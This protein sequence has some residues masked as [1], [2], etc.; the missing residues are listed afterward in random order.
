[1]VVALVFLGAFGVVGFFLAALG[2]GVDGDSDEPSNESSALS[3]ET[4]VFLGLVAF[5]VVF[6]GVAA[7]LEDS[8]L[9]MGARGKV[10]SSPSFES[11]T[12]FFFDV[13][14]IGVFLTGTES[15]SLDLEA[16]V[17]RFY[18]TK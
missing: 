6:F 11:T 7:F 1:V 5:V 18:S 2:F 14:L 9:K 10:F 4:V 8:R 17:L 13:L 3:V 15:V 16:A 12:T